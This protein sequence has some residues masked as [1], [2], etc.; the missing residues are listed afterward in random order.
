MK[1]IIALAALAVLPAAANAELL[2]SVEGFASFSEFD[3][4]GNTE[5]SDGF[6][7]RGRVNLPGT[8]LFARAEYLDEELD[9][10]ADYEET[11]IG[12]G[13][14]TSLTPLVDVYGEAQYLD[15]ETAVPGLGA[16]DGYGA[17]VGLE[18]NLPLATLYGRAGLGWLDDADVTELLLG[19][20]IGLGLVGLFAEYR[21]LTLEP[22]NGGDIDNDGF[23]VGL[24]VAF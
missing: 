20:R 8:G 7:L 10:G 13:Y 1:K 21:M 11:R 5:D 22:D 2:A 18:A 4:G 15:F 9:G 17:F 6:G 3:A 23:R 14:S 19:A 24:H 12:G 16:Q